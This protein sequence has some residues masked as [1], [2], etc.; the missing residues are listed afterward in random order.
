ML[1]PDYSLLAGFH[2]EWEL[3]QHTHTDTH[4]HT[5][6][7][8]NTHN[9]P[10]VPFPFE[11]TSVLYP[12]YSLLAGFHVEWELQREVLIALLRLNVNDTLYNASYCNVTRETGKLGGRGGG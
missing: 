5:N 8:T 4:T 9:T 11:V 12:E 2:V 1:Y 10:G 6:T 7:H 3:Q